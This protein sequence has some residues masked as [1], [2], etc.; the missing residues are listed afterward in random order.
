M[1]A[2]RPEAS[3]P[4]T[5]DLKPSAWNGHALLYVSGLSLLLLAGLG[6][7]SGLAGQTT[8]PSATTAA[9]AARLTILCDN[10]VAELGVKAVWG[11][12]CLVEARGHTVL[13]DTGGDPAVLKDNLAAL[14]VDPAKIEAVV[15]SH[16]HADHTLGAPGLGKLSG[17]RVFIPRSVDGHTNE[18]AALQAAGLKLVPVAQATPLFD[19]ITVSEPLRSGCP[20]PKSVES[21][22]P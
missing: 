16:Y 12:A 19:G 7:A 14:E 9:P 13:F 20:F 11:F 5:R 1:N 3:N 22:R 15:I 2:Y 18:T 6:S 4:K 8:P 21:G 10:A 17:V